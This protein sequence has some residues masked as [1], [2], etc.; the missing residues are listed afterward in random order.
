LRYSLGEIAQITGG[1]ILQGEPSL[2]VK[3]VAIDS[4]T[5]VSGSLFCA[6][7]GERVDGHDFVSGVSLKGALGALVERP[8]K[9]ADP[10]FGLVLVKS[11]VAALGM[12][13]SHYRNPMPL[14][15]V[16]ITGS[17][18]K[19]STKDL[20]GSVLSRRFKTYKNPG[21]LN[22][23]IGLPLAVLGM[24]PGY[25]YAVLEMAMRARGEIRDLCRIAKPKIG[26]LTDISASH[27]GVLGSLEEIA[28][29][30]AELLEFLPQDGTAFLCWDSEMI[31][32]VSQ[33]ANCRKIS[34]GFHEEC[35]CR[36]FDIEPTGDTSSRFRV[37]FR[38]SEFAFQLN[39][40]GTHQ[41]QNALAA[42]AI[43]FELGLSAE[44]I[45]CGLTNVT[46]SPMRQEI[47]KTKS[48]T[49]INDAYNASVKS[50]KAALDL[51]YATGKG[52][53]VAIL[54]DILEMGE[55]GPEAHFEVGS[56]ARQKADALVAIG[57]LGVHIKRGWDRA[58]TQPSDSA[59]WF[60]D[61]KSAMDFIV[62]FLKRG[63]TCLVKAS[64]G[65]EF[66]SLVACLED[67]NGHGIGDEVR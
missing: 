15:V 44:E 7:P 54:G 3:T 22:S 2:Q 60:L 64:R 53:K 17:V 18:G 28:L 65:M 21:N 56:Y 1:I 63:D 36:G 61:K 51:L 24:E 16:G 23:D 27:I 19:T 67:F 41:V 55:Y 43:G 5:D 20:I 66:E 46:L 58:E 33:F 14:T 30:K 50:M 6:I 9:I 29:S 13:A 57:S 38:G 45:G 32:N 48:L 39:M 59:S 35:D 26:V 34:Y 37:R 8:L 12:L 10:E 42:V 11:T 49:I 47:V 52:R 40:A 62:R 4:R 25:S 31:R